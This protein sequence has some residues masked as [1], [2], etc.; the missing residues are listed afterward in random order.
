VSDQLRS[1]W[2]A[3]NGGDA[4]ASLAMARILKLARLTGQRR[5]EIAATRISDLDLESSDPALVI[6]RGRAKNHHALRVPLSPL[7]LA[8]FRQAVGEAGTSGFVFPNPTGTGHIAPRSVS[9]AMERN[10]DRLGLGDIRVHDLR[11]TVGSMMTRFGVPHP[12]ARAQPW[13]QN[14]QRNRGGL[15][16]VRLRSRE[17]RGT[18]VVGGRSVLRRGGASCWRLCRWAPPRKIRFAAAS[19]VRMR[20][21]PW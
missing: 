10:R 2:S 16:L 6:A 4:I 20:S 17:A 18:G 12:R 11:R 21:R 1:L 14:G 19:A 8:E 15:S 7:A 5:A 13:R 9:K 3:L